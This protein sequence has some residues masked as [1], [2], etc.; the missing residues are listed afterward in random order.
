MNNKKWVVYF[1]SG[2]GYREGCEYIFAKSR[3][4]A[5]ELY[6]RYFNIKEECIAVPVFSARRIN[7]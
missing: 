3:N 6:R 2:E 1:I 7:D 5:I 4:E